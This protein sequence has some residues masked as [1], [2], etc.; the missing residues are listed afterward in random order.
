MPPP[1]ALVEALRDHYVIERELGRGGMATVYLAYDL[2][3]DRRVALK[4]LHPELAA[5][6]GPERFQR[7]IRTAARLQHPHILTVFDSGEAGTAERGGARLWFTMPYVEG[8]SLRDRLRREGQLPIDDALRIAVEAARG[9]DY[10]HQHGVIHRDVKP[11]NI[12]LTDDGST[13]VADFGIARALGAGGEQLTETGVVVGTPA[14]MSPEQASGDHST[15]ARADLY[16]LGCVLYEMLTGEPPFSGPTTQAIMAKRMAAEAPRVRV[17]RP[18]ASETIEHA[19]ARALA[20]A[21]ADR[22]RSMAEFAR[23]LS[24]RNAPTAV[25]AAGG[26]RRWRPAVIGVAIAG[27]AAL[28]LVAAVA[29]GLIPRE[30][31]MSTGALVPSDELVLVDFANHANDR[32]LATAVTEAFRVDFAQSRLVRLASPPRVRAA[33]QRMQLPD[34]VPLT[35]ESGREIAQREGIKAVLS[36]EVSRLGDGYVV[37]ATLVSADSGRVLA[38]ERETAAS[39]GQIIGA[40]DRLS[41]HLRRRIGESLRSVRAEPPLEAVTTASLDALRRY[42]LGAQAR[43]AGRWGDALAL[44]EDAVRL[45]STFAMAWEQLGLV[46]WDMDRDRARQQDATS[47]AYRLRERLTE[48]ERYSVEGQYAE[49]VLDDR[50]QARRAYRSLLALDPT[51]AAALKTLGLLAWFDDDLEEAESMAARAIRADSGDVAPW[52]NLVDAQV[53]LGRTAAAESTLA[54]WRTRLG[55]SPTFEIQVGLMAGA[56]AQYDSADRAFRRALAFHE[57]DSERARAA[58]LLATL[59]RIRGRLRESRQ[60]ERRAAELDGSRA[61]A[62]RPAVAEAWFDVY[63]GNSRDAAVRRLDSL[64]ASDAFAATDPMDRPYNQMRFL[65]TMAGRPD[66]GA[67]LRR[68]AEAALRAAG[69]RGERNLQSREWRMTDCAQQGAAALQKKLYPTAAERFRQARTINPRFRWLPE[70]ATAYD[71]AGKSD[72]ALAIYEQY[73]ASTENFRLYSDANNL[74]PILQRAGELYEARG[75]REGAMQAYQRFVDLWR[76]ADPELQP[77]VTE[78]RRRMAALAAERS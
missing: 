24:D 19:I 6:L 72:S 33:L 26:R 58:D 3:H 23:A 53:S 34:S 1:P 14:Y 21:P 67:S 40:V 32:S 5:A 27:I 62:L 71:R 51:D 45:D 57:E 20:R 44:Y 12:L 38:A 35:A 16:A 47:R 70:L 17:L 39:A 46:L 69:P 28:A 9:L 73:L 30:S 31:L 49:W 55:T 75:N 50:A 2:K 54:R 7:E 65:Y 59:A 78:V 15:D 43:T 13:L 48:R 64:I 68:T 8:E 77:Q 74:L 41:R 76:D 11:E 22:F 42:S 63:V 60:L 56:Q 4:V 36:G 37:S 66:R 29:L 52:T 10:A 61:G 18:A 25:V